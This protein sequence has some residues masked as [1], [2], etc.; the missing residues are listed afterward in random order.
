MDLPGEGTI[1]RVVGSVSASQAD[2][3]GAIAFLLGA[4]SRDIMDAS[5]FADFGNRPKDEID[6]T[7]SQD[8]N[9]VQAIT[10]PPGTSAEK[11]W[12]YTVDQRGQRKYR[13][14]DVYNIGMY[15]RTAAGSHTINFSFALRVLVE[16]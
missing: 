15:G 16:F 6:D 3:T 1:K 9:F 8:F 12:T 7:V 4:V 13:Q 11:Y 10:M 5:E 14:G 2:T